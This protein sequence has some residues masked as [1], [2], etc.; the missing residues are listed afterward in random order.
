MNTD[1]TKIYE[2]F[3]KN[4]NLPEAKYKNSLPEEAKYNSTSNNKYSITNDFFQSSELNV[5]GNENEV[6]EEEIITEE[7]KSNDI[8]DQK[9][10]IKQENTEVK[11]LFKNDLLDYFLSFLDSNS[12][13]NYVLCGYFTKF[14]NFLFNKDASFVNTVLKL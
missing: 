1:S 4:E 7:T 9:I 10:K 8:D 13:L 3:L 5:F 2:F 14:F 12:E 6:I 11:L